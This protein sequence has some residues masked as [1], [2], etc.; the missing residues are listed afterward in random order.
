MVCPTRFCCS[1]GK[2]PVLVI[3]MLLIIPVLHDSKV[4]AGENGS[5]QGK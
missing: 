1:L 4:A 3:K 2:V 5:E